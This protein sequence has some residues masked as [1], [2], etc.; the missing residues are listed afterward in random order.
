[1][2][3]IRTDYTGL[4]QALHWASALLLI[5]MIG[6]GLTMT[7][8][9]EGPAQEGL[10]NAHVAAGLLVLALTAVRVVALIVRRWP[11]PPDGLSPLN[12]AAYLAT[13]TL[14]YVLL[15]ALLASGVGMLLAS[16]VAPVPGGIAP[17]DVADSAARVAHSALSKVFGAL[18]VVHVA[19][20][21]RH[22]LTK[23]GAFARMGVRWFERAG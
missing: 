8:I 16:G 20:V 19:G 10:Y 17:G 14:L 22:Q 3:T 12:R 21:V 11:A 5:G 15:V 9:G 1:M 13:H 18:L 23:G 4:A 7:R 2:A 6:A